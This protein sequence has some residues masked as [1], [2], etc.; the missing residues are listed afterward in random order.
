M[1]FYY[2]YNIIGE[3]L[4][5]P[6]P[7]LPGAPYL[8]AS[9][10]QVLRT[11]EV[12]ASPLCICLIFRTKWK[13]FL[14]RFQINHLQKKSLIE[15]FLIGILIYLNHYIIVIYEKYNDTLILV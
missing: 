6:P 5:D 4:F 14:H 15:Y 3:E 8:I 9:M 12:H 2:H 11:Y 1:F 13:E 7:P 10:M